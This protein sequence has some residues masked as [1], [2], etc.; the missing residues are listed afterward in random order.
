M[1]KTDR[2][3]SVFTGVAIALVL[4]ASSLDRYAT[5]G[6]ASALLV[7]GLVLFPKMRRTGLVAAGIAFAAAVVMLL[8]RTR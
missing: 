6:L 4:L 8:I 3:V 5:L 2:R 1:I 7:I